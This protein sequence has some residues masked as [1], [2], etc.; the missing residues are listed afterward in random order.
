[1]LLIISSLFFF[2]IKSDEFARHILFEQEI[3]NQI[4]FGSYKR[5][6]ISFDYY[7]LLLHLLVVVMIFKLSSK[8]VK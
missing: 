2:S 1:M 7:F 4:L 3:I 8:L 6:F 5:I